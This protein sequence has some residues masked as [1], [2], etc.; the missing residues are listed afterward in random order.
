MSKLWQKN[1]E[2][3]NLIVEAFET[4]DDLLLDEKLTEFDI[5]GSLAHAK[6][7][8]KIGILTSD[9]LKKL[10]MGL[11]EISRLTKEGRFNLEMGD[12]DVHTK[13]ENYLTREENPYCTK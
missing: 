10:K 11:N 9:E 6:M 12:E 5:K 1:K 7:L 2:K 13:I 4:S 8:C 3:L